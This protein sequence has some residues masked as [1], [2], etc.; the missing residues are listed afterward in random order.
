MSIKI[1]GKELKIPI[2]Q[3]GMGIGVSLGN[4]AGNV[5]KTGAMGTISFVNPGYREDDFKNNSFNANLRAFEKEVKIARNICGKENLLAVNIMQAATKSEK[6]IEFAGKSDIDAVVVGAG[7]PLELPKLVGEDKAIAPIISSARAFELISRN[8]KKKYSRLPDFT[9]FEGP[10]AGGH[11]GFKDI[12]KSFDFW[13]ELKEILKVRDKYQEIKGSRIYV[14]AAG[15]FADH[16]S[17]KKALKN[18]ADGIQAGTAFLMTN[19]SGF[20]MDIKRKILEN[21]EKMKKENKESILI[22]KSP[23]GMPARA[24]ST[25]FLKEVES[26]RIPS[27][28]C[29]NCL[30]H[31]DP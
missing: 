2:I 31:C 25:P 13:K 8:W 21:S 17:F 29:I 19:E 20:S 12:N 9:I 23:V 6:Y 14:F 28:R 18:N 1:N 27:K 24:V 15:G 3:G 26:G 11:L 5:S 10:D 30:T 4:L 22:I 7:L 16:K